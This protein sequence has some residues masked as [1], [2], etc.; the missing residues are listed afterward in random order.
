MHGLDVDD[1]DIR[2]QNDQN[3]R[4]IGDFTKM[5]R[6]VPI[7]KKMHEIISS[8]KNWKAQFKAILSSSASNETKLVPLVARI[9]RACKWQA[10]NATKARRQSLQCR[11]FETGDQFYLGKVFNFGSCLSIQQRD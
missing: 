3:T 11:F 7:M 8:D 10:Q 2:S 9:E 6:L 4:I 1:S 5:V